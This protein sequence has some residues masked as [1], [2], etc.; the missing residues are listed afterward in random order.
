MGEWDPE[1]ARDKGWSLVNTVKQIL[2]KN[3]FGQPTLL[4][5]AV[6]SKCGGDAKVARSLR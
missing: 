3:P 2:S 1:E 4:V 5:L 6:Q